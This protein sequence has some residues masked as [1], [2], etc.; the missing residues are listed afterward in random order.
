MFS[1]SNSWNGKRRDAKGDA[2]RKYLS[3]E[4]SE[5]LIVTKTSFLMSDPVL[6]YTYTCA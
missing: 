6:N 3:D 2:F 5:G 1:S 4:T